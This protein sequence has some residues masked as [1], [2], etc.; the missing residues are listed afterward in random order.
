MTI[1]HDSV[2]ASSTA[3]AVVICVCVQ[4]GKLTTS[5]LNLVKER[6]N[7]VTVVFQITPT[8]YSGVTTV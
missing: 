2:D 3:T 4:L 8:G 7:P 5:F 1:D 6:N